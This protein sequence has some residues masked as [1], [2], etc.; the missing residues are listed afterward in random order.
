MSARTLTLRVLARLCVVV[1]LLAFSAAPAWAVVPDQFGGAGE[2]AGQFI[3][4][5][6]M[7]VDQGNGYVYL[8]D[9]NNQRV[10][11]FTA[12]GAFVL[13]WG[14]GVAD[15]RTEALQTCTIA[16][17]KGFSGP[18]AGELDF[19][20][21]VAVDND[22]FSSSYE[23]VYVVDFRNQR[24]EKFS[25]TGELLLTFAVEATGPAIAVDAEGNVYV[26]GGSVQEFSS[27]GVLLGKVALPGS[28]RSLAVN[29][30]GDLYVDLAA[31]VQEYSSSGTL[32]NT[33]DAGG[34]ANTVAL[35][36][37][38]DV[39]IYDEEPLS[40]QFNQ[41]LEYSS[42]GTEMASFDGADEP[43]C[44]KGLTWG[45]KIDRLYELCKPNSLP[46][47]VRLVPL[48]P[49]GALLVGRGSVSGVASTSVTL[50]ATVNPEGHATRYRF[51]YGPSESYG[52]SVPV[53]EG[54]LAGGFGNEPLQVKLK[55]LTAGATY[56]YRVVATS[57]FG[58]K[59]YVTAGED[60]TFTLLPAVSI[61]EVYANDV[62]STSVTFGAQ[63]NS[64]G[65]EASYRLEYGTSTSYGTVVSEGPIGAGSSDVMV[66]PTHVQGLLPDTVYHYRVVAFDEREGVAYT[67]EGSDQTFTTQ[68]AGR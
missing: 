67:V 11:K 28:S 60:A 30:S 23:D 4:A 45:D 43:S 46:E 21:G 39:F 54:S 3:E 35:D 6:G 36:S 17:F 50:N 5:R 12:E 49:P 65:V 41:I 59:T 61:D 16:C 40:P 33:L 48:P 32:L 42:S 10:E 29:A 47:F 52:S 20:E 68:A 37:S 56:H 51:E 55:G 58:G 53:S 7:A 24:V 57:E 15:G 62:A 22:L 63:L 14:W 2:G 1:G 64:L 31:G 27:G 19:P 18:G 66:G 44:G 25:P 9:R 26:G 34:H 13:G 8:V 38:G